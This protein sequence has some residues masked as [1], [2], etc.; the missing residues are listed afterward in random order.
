MKGKDE[1]AILAIPLA[2]GK[3]GIAVICRSRK[4]IFVL[5]F[6]SNVSNSLEE[7]S[8][9]QFGF[10]KPQDAL[11]V[12]RV[13][14]LGVQESRWHVVG[15]VNPW[16]RSIWGQTKFSRVLDSF[17][18]V[19]YFEDEYSDDEPTE[20]LA[21]KRITEEEAAK[22]PRSALMGSEFAEGFL[23]R[24]SK[25]ELTPFEKSFLVDEG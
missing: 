1:G 6:Y 16:D 24:L 22:L 4:G 23:T 3:W 12:A 7:A 18:P 25:N 2:N 21:E 14:N 13:G 17:P 9:L 8:S 5:R 20:H 19:R 10:L 11:A 15:R